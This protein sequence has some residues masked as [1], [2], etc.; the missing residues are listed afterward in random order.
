MSKLIGCESFS[1][2]PSDTAGITIGVEEVD[3]EGDSPGI[4]YHLET[5]RLNTQF[6][7][8]RELYL[9]AELYELFLSSRLF[10]IHDRPR[11]PLWQLPRHL[12]EQ[13]HPIFLRGSIRDFL[14]LLQVRGHLDLQMTPQIRTFV[15][16]F[17]AF[18]V[19]VSLVDMDGLCRRTILV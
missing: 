8:E 6:G 13:N 10:L 3:F 19:G 18:W 5:M 16:S 4:L 12:Q 1:A 2:P 15:D 17:Y 7:R 14:P 9:T 11:T